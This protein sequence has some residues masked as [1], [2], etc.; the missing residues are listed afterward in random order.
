MIISIKKLELDLFQFCHCINTRRK[1]KD[2]R[3]ECFDHFPQELDRHFKAMDKIMAT[4]AITQLF[5]LILAAEEKLCC[6]NQM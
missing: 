3:L 4:I 5:P 1:T 2:I 6:F